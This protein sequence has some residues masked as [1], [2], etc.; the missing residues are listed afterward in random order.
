MGFETI[1]DPQTPIIEHWDKLNNGRKIVGFAAIDA[2]ENQNLRARYLPD[3]RIQWVGN[4]AKNIDT[5]EVKFWNK[6]LFSAPDQ[7]GWVFKF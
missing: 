3:G 4:N 6:W 7:S 5:M 2:H 1:F